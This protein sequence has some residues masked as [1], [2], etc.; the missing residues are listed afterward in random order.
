MPD[1]NIM[2]TAYSLAHD[3]FPS[4][5]SLYQVGWFAYMA[6]GVT[7]AW[8]TMYSLTHDTDRLRDVAEL[9]RLGH[10]RILDLEDV[11]EFDV[12]WPAYAQFYRRVRKLLGVDREYTEIKERIEILFR[13][14]Q[15]EQRAREERIRKE[16]IRLGDEEQRLA[17]SRS[18]AVEGGAAVVGAFL[19]LVSLANVVVDAFRNVSAGYFLAALVGSGV[20]A[21]VGVIGFFALRTRVRRIDKKRE[22]A[23][24][25]LAR[26]ANSPDLDHARR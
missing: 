12:A 24:A 6:V 9:S 3:K 4:F 7:C 1:E 26:V 21:A 19:L 5:S 10:D 8:Q 18:H 25:A 14:A 16:E 2:I 20:I 17:L 13:F 23:R 15:A 22:Q 11:Y